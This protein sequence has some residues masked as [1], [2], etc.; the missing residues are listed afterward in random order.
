MTFIQLM[1]LES[2]KADKTWRGTEYTSLVWLLVLAE[3]FGEV[4]RAVHDAEYAAGPLEAIRD[5]LV[6]VA[7]IAERFAAWLEQW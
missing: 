5:E 6:Q 7:S 4:A 2:E 1:R 3:E